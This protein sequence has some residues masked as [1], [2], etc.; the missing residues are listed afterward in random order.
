MMLATRIRLEEATVE[1]MMLELDRRGLPY[2]FASVGIR[3]DHTTLLCRGD[4]ISDEVAWHMLVAA[5]DTV[6]DDLN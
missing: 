5:A 4:A 2:V 6:A 1:D 3:P